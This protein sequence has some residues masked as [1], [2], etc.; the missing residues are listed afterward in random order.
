[1]VKNM[2]WTSFINEAAKLH[3]KKKL[4]INADAPT[5]NR[6]TWELIPQIADTAASH[7]MTR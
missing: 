4:M 3:K 6:V 2:S 7:V 1:M 5:T